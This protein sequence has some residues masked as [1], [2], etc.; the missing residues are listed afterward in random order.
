MQIYGRVSEIVPEKW[1]TKIRVALNSLK[2]LA[3]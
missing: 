3:Q 1:G 2:S